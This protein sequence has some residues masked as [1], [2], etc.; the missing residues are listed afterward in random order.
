MPNVN[1][2]VGLTLPFLYLNYLLF[3]LFVFNL[4]TFNELCGCVEQALEKV[5]EYCKHHEK[6]E[7]AP[8]TSDASKQEHSVH[9]ISAWD[10]QFM[11]VEMGLLFDIILV[12][13][14]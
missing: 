10:K 12:R 9:N 3:Q 5:I 2:K 1:A 7:P 4:F 8:A 11:Q 14:C 6:D 13:C